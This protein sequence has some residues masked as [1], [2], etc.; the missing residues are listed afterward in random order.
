MKRLIQNWF[1]PV[2]IIVF[3]FTLASHADCSQYCHPD[4]SK[5][6]GGG[7]ISKYKTCRT[8]WTT[9]CSGE[10]PKSETSKSYE[11]PTKIEP[12]QEPKSEN[13]SEAK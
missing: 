6:C 12:G 11:N 2:Y 13:K 4:R 3:L 8:S 9:A 10:R 5:P 7:C 1:I